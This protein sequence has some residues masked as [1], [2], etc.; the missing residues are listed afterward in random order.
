[1]NLCDPVFTWL[2]SPV[3][4]VCS[5]GWILPHEERGTGGGTNSYAS[6]VACICGQHGSTWGLWTVSACRR[7]AEQALLILLGQEASWRVISMSPALGFNAKR[8]PGR[9]YG[10][11]S[12]LKGIH[13]RCLSH[14]S[15]GSCKPVRAQAHMEVLCCQHCTEVFWSSRALVAVQYLQYR[16]NE[17][18]CL[19]IPIYLSAYFAIGKCPVL[20]CRYCYCMTQR[21]SCYTGMFSF[22]C[23]VKG[24]GAS[25]LWGSAMHQI[26]HELAAIKNAFYAYLW[27]LG[28][29][30]N[31]AAS[32]S[33][34]FLPQYRTGIRLI[35]LSCCQWQIEIV[36]GATHKMF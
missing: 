1:M 22:F 4:A 29:I 5:P 14:H 15:G 16:S 17:M 25:L 19:L 27:K 33:F 3:L 10:D 32:L 7:R 2:F 9:N 21:D 36:A 28:N 12:R 30:H 11:L 24:K 8:H 18:D 34:T 20:F 26:P 31:D 35:K 13:D 23:Q 6:Q